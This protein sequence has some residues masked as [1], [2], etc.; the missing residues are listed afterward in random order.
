M[1]EPRAVSISFENETMRVLLDDQRTLSI[2]LS[3]FPRLQRASAEHL[4]GYL[5][6]AAGVHWE[7][8]DEDISVAHLLAGHGDRH[9]DTEA[10]K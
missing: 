7:A 9:A 2:P 10:L 4:S 5:I 8:L 1:N 3:R 6:S